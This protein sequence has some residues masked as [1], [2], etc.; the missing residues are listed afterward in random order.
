MYR[1]AVK[2]LRKLAKQYPEKRFTNSEGE[3][4]TISDV[5][6]ALDRV[7]KWVYKELCTDDITKVTRCR[8]CKFYKK[9]KKKTGFKPQ[10]FQA[11]SKDMQ[12][13]DPSFFCKDGDEN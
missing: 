9:Y 13:R 1:L 10:V 7:S 5:A 11:C 3:K 6:N 12:K 8:N 2:L 4:A